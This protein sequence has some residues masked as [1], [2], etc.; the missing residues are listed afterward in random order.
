MSIQKNL[1]EKDFYGWTVDTVN[2]LKNKQYEQI[3]IMHLTE[4][5]ESMGINNHRELMI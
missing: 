5:I 3:D 2:K 1:Y 4:E